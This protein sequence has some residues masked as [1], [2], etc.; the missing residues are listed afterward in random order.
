[1][2][3]QPSGGGWIT[4]GGTDPARLRQLAATVTEQPQEIPP[5][6]SPTPTPTPHRP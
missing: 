6:P 2:R 1:V 4:I 5:M 3:W